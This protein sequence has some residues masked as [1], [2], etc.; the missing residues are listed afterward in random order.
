MKLDNKI[1]WII[2]FIC[3]PLFTFSA[4]N[5]NAN[6]E[7]SHMALL[8]LDFK[9]SEKYLA[10]EKKNTI[11]NTYV[12]YLESY[13][14]FLEV[15]FK[16]RASDFEIF[17]TKSDAC[18]K[19]LKLE[20]EISEASELASIVYIQKAFIH[21]LWNE[22]YQYA[23]AYIKGQA[24]LEKM[25]PSHT[26]YL[27]MASLYEVIGGSIPKSYKS[28]AKLFNFTGNSSKGLKMIQDY[29]NLHK[30]SS[31]LRT[32]GQIIELYIH[33]LLDLPKEINNLVLK[34][35]LLLNYVKLQN[36]TLK[37]STQIDWINQLNTGH[38]DLPDYFTFLKAKAYLNLQDSMGLGFMDT[39][40]KEHEG[41]S[42]KHAAH[43]YKYWYY[44][45]QG[46]PT[47]SH[48]EKAQLTRLPDPIFPL[49]K[50]LTKRIAKNQN[51][52]FLIQSRML[53][54]AQAYDKALIVL[55]NKDAKR[56]LKS[57][58]EKIEFLYRLARIYEKKKKMNAA[59][60]LYQKVIDTQQSEF[61][62][63]AFSAYNLGKIHAK[64]KHTQLAKSYF[65]Q[66]LDLNKGE[67][68]Q[69]IENKCSFAIEMLKK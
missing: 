15:Y 44:S 59:I 49:D 62:F 40:L 35:A 6:I 39:F 10:I 8:N 26:E 23:K 19:L 54:D 2:I 50:K 29:L 69:S 20:T 13:Q 7:K 55:K 17:K 38:S 46:N 53:F 57:E 37:A 64:L 18:L 56:S 66:A 9:T 32:E 67:Y 63:V 43:F 51:N 25:E 14:S 21:S 12:N 45:A 16:M 58:A 5:Y 42:L 28:L 3:S 47:A 68:Q 65:L 27:K 41:L 52:A 30:P 34:D 1:L 61:Y 4:L 60:Q 31:A 22:P 48:S 33:Q 36:Q 24:E 11:Q